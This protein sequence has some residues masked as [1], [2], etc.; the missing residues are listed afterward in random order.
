[1]GSGRFVLD[2]ELCNPIPSPAVTP[3]VDLLPEKKRDPQGPH[4]PESLTPVLPFFCCFGGTK[5]S[6][7][8]AE[9]LK[10][11]GLCA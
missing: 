6:Q 7:S 8:E 9:T 4:T 2:L 3:E 5:R 11:E 10:Q 1:M